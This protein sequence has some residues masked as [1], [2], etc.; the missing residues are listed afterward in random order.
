MDVATARKP[1]PTDLNDEQWAI[2]EPLIPPAK[3][4]GS[5]R[6]VKMREVMNTLFYLDRTGCQWGMLPH[7]LLPKSTVY[8]YFALWRRDGTW[9]RLVDALRQRVRQEGV[10][11]HPREP[12]P[13]AASIDSQ[14]VKTT[15]M[16]GTRGY[17]GGKKITGRKRHLCV[18]TLGLLLAVVVTSAAV[19]DAAAAPEVLEQMDRKH[20][21]R[22]QKIW[23]DS[24]YHN[25][26]L[27]EWISKNRPGD[28]EL[29]IKSRPANTKGFVLIPK[30]WVVERTNAWMGRYRRNSKDYEK[31]TSSSEC[32]IRLS[33]M[34]TMLRR[35]RPSSNVQVFNYR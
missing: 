24:K 20:F 31:L 2:L 33:A 7:D 9:Q 19:D 22:L 18:D 1:Y 8:D 29:E 15:E 28:W 26:R 3:H 10:Y 21:P 4:G 12:S 5:P 27:K 14:S 34:Q 11:D 32:M 23:A 17:D 25:Y 16:G 35:L 30:R 6:T 13:S